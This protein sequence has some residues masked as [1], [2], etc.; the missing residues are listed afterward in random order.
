MASISLPLGAAHSS[1]GQSDPY[2]DELGTWLPATSLQRCSGHQSNLSLL[3]ETALCLFTEADRVNL[4]PLPL[5]GNGLNSFHYFL[6]NKVLIGTVIH[7]DFPKCADL[8]RLFSNCNVQ[9]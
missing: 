3:Q 1:P 6:C 8:S 4:E 5:Q 9:K 7:L 2:G